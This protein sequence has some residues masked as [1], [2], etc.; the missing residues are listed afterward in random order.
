MQGRVP[1]LLSIHARQNESAHAFHAR[2]IGGRFQ[3][4]PIYGYA[5]LLK[6]G[7][8]AMAEQP[9]IAIVDDDRWMRRSLERLLKAAGFRAE[10][11]ISAEHYLAAGNHQGTECIILDVGLPGISGFELERRL[12][13]EQKRL[14]IV[15][16]SAHDEPGIRDKAANAGAVAFL[17]KPFDD[18]ALLDAI[19]SALR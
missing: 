5:R 6:L 19:S 17:G 15:F 18:N 1:E 14:P 9:L 12:K 2:T 4:I 16:V 3:W 10:A 11:F 13:A 7:K 8:W